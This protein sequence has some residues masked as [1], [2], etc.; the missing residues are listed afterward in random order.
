MTQKSS[1]LNMKTIILYYSFTYDLID[2]AQMK[3]VIYAFNILSRF[4]TMIADTLADVTLII[5]TAYNFYISNHP[6]QRCVRHKR[7]EAVNPAQLKIDKRDS[8]HVGQCR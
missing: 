4:G 7:A 3:Q 8:E 2:N 6:P 5:A 1:D